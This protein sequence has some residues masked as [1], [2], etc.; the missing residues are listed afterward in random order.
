MSE[1]QILQE[2]KQVAV[3]RVME[4]YY[5]AMAT[6]EANVVIRGVEYLLK[7]RDD[8]EAYKDVLIG[9]SLQEI[10]AEDTI[11]VSTGERIAVN[12]SEIEDVVLAMYK[13][14]K[15]FWDKK[16]DK[17]E[18]IESSLTPEAADSVVW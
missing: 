1:E 8:Y 10:N 15:P 7:G 13:V 12:K 14:G 11:Q 5:I 17:I 2:R 16:E 4:G 6:V 9:L 3:A 18:E